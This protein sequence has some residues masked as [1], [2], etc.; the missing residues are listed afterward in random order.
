MK[1]AA[2]GAPL[3]GLKV[4]SERRVL[5]SLHLFPPCPVLQLPTQ[6]PQLGSAAVSLC[7]NAHGKAP[8]LCSQRA[9]LSSHLTSVFG[10]LE[11]SY[12]FFVLSFLQ[13]MQ[14]ISVPLWLSSALALE[15]AEGQM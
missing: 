13:E 4:Y 12:K 7:L 5:C 15:H 3:V 10:G 2:H 1:K 9:K 11:K 14:A 6:S 8:R